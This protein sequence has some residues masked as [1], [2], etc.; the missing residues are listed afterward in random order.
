MFVLAN[1]ISATAGLL[2]GVLYCLELIIIVRVIL[3]WANAD[4]SNALVKT[5]QAISEPV[6]KPFRKLMPPWKMNGLD[7]SPVLA[8]LAI[9]FMKRFLISTLFD[10]AQKLK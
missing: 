4:P 10:I 5:L 9:E 7:L 2:D 8:I 3:S 6:L 1:F